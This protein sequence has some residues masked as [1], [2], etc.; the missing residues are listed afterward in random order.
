LVYTTISDGTLH[1]VSLKW[2]QGFVMFSN[3]Y[4]FEH[5][6]KCGKLQY[7]QGTFSETMWEM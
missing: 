1:F 4:E 5:V 2:T 6:A 7:V 3:A